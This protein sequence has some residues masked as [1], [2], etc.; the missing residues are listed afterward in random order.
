MVRYSMWFADVTEIYT[1]SNTYFRLSLF[2]H[3]LTLTYACHSLFRLITTRQFFLNRPIARVTIFTSDKGGGKRFCNILRDNRRG[4]SRGN[5]NVGCGT[6]KRRFCNCC[7][8]H[9]FITVVNYTICAV[10]IGFIHV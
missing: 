6:L 8:L 1:E 4:V 7:K 5:K 2:V 10:I 3:L 9:N